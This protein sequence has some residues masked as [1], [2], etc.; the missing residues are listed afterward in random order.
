MIEWERLERETVYEGHVVQVHLDTVR[1]RSPEGSRET[2]YDVVHHP[3][4]AS[5]VPL[6]ADGAVALV[7]QFRYPVGGEILEIP[8]GSLG[9]GE[10][11]EACARRELEEEVGV[12]GGTWSELATFYTT[13]G[14]CDEEMRVFLVE[15]L[16]VGER[17][18]DRDEHLRVLRLP[19]AEAL[20]KIARGEIHDAKTIVGLHTA[21]ARLEAEGRWPLDSGRE[22]GTG[23]EGRG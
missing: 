9:D 15:D 20:R 8:A 5:M 2:E 17:S 3:G 11:F 1:V 19:F 16:E 22:P 21:R 7:R 14:F 6:F 18:L 4:A 10:T 13:P 12:R 23:P